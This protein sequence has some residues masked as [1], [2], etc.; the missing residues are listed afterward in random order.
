VVDAAASALMQILVNYSRVP[1][2]WVVLGRMIDFIDLTVLFADVQNEDVIQ[3][4]IVAVC[5]FRFS[6]YFCPRRIVQTVRFIFPRSQSFLQFI[7]FSN[8]QND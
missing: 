7:T 1:S 5:N 4:L 8:T 3:V 6:T 2:S